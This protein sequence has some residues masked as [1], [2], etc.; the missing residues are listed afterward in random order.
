MVSWGQQYP[1]AF[2][3]WFGMVLPILVIHHP[4]YAKNILVRGGTSLLLVLGNPVLSSTLPYQQNHGKLAR[5]HPF[6]WLSS[7]LLEFLLCSPSQT[8]SPSQVSTL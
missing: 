5:N 1:Y 8:T 7:Q 3:R 6:C 4:E 2:P